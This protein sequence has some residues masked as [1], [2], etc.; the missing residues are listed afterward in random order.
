MRHN[1]RFQIQ[2]IKAAKGDRFQLKMGMDWNEAG[3][4]IPAHRSA[5]AGCL[6]LE[7]TH[8]TEVDA[9]MELSRLREWIDGRA[10]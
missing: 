10:A 4:F 3:E 5:F 1:Y 9:S 6:E 2:R 7:P 8:P